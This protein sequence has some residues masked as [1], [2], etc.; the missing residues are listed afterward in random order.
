[1]T[2]QQLSKLRAQRTEKQKAV[3]AL[4]DAA[5][6]RTPAKLTPEEKAQH[7]S[8]RQEIQDINELLEHAEQAD[9]EAEAHVPESQHRTPARANTDDTRHTFSTVDATPEPGAAI[10]TI[11]R[12]TVMFGRDRRAAMEWARDTYGESSPQYNALGQTEFTAGGALVPETLSRE[13]IELRRAQSVV[14][15][16]NPTRVDL[17]NGTAPIPKITGGAT[18]SYSG[19]NDPITPSEE[20]FGQL[21]LT[22]KY[23]TALVPVSNQLLKNAGLSVDM[24]I[25]DDLVASLATK[26]DQAFIRGLGTEYSPKGMRYWAPAANV[27]AIA[28]S[29]LANVRTDIKALINALELANVRMLRPAF[30]MNPRS[31]NYL[32]WDMVDGNGNLVFNAQ[33]LQGMLN[34]FPVGKTTN[35]PTNLGGGSETEIYLV[36]MADAVIGESAS[37]TIDASSEATYVD[38]GTTKSAFQRNQTVVRAIAAHD[39]GMRHDASV[40]VKTGVTY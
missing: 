4:L 30:L 14:R 39:F 31:V 9:A 24:L 38:A 22:E 17:I 13:I 27:T 37:L 8:L 19:E 32:A 23:L 16:L 40:A 12:A 26:E 33:L 21:K 1:M 7:A 10:G 5:A 3:A 29:T 11:V 18:A 35:I 15:R 6:E 2:K 25:R 36:D 34:G 20:T 28:G